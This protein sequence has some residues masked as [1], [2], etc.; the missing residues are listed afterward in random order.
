MRTMV[1]SRKNGNR[2]QIYLN[3]EVRKNGQDPILV[4]AQR[5]Q[6]FFDSTND[7]IAVFNPSGDVVDANPQLLK[8]FGYSYDAIVSKSMDVLFDVKSYEKLCLRFQ[9]LF[10][11]RARKSPIE[12]DLLT[13]SGRQRQVEISLSLLKGQYGYS[14][15][16][17]AIIRDVTRRKRI[18]DRSVQRAEELQKV[19]NAVPTILIV[20][21]RRK[22]I[23]K[24]NRSGLEAFHKE[25]R[26]VVG[27]RIGEALGCANH[28]SSLKGC[29]FGNRCRKCVIRQ[30]MLRCLKIGE[31]IL[32]VEEAIIRDSLK[33]SLF[34]YKIN[35]VPLEARGKRWGVV[36]LEDITAKKMAEL[37]SLKLHNSIARSNLELKKTLENFAQSQSRL[38]ESQKL[39]QIGLL[40]SGLAHNLKT[41]LSGI[42]GYSQL[43][44]MD[45]PDMKELDLI[46][47]ETE[48]MESIINNLMLKSRKEHENREEILNLNEILKI[49]LEFLSANMFYKHHVTTEIHLD[50]SLPLITGVYSHF[51]QSIMNIIQN[52]LDA[53]YLTD[54]KKLTIQTKHDD[55]YV[56][57]VV[58]DTG[59][60]IPKESIEKV[61]DIFYTTKP[62]TSNRREDE[63]YG[64][65][66]GLSSANYFIH[67]Y[68][69]HISLS[70][71]I[72]KGTTVTIQI[73]HGEKK[74]PQKI[75]RALIVDDSDT[76]VDML[77]RICQDIGIEAYGTTNGEKALELYTKLKPHVIV[78]DLCMP[79]LTG[80]EMMSEIRKL[81]ASQ[82]VVYISGYSE[83]PE[84][85]DWLA[86]EEKH[87]SLSAFLKKPFPMDSFIKVLQRMVSE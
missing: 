61:F 11:G 34:Y 36:S 54:E 62:T 5:Y 15:A 74:E 66:L 10:E 24:V 39:E 38:L 65:G 1:V 71:E 75:H 44:Q 7:A 8:L 49:E 78:T 27:R 55:K 69:G 68:G 19:F 32:N 85:R 18:E 3:P 12:C 51:S 33:D 41:P 14:K 81:N 87:P 63:P 6:A 56:C 60:G 16:I 80:P 82:H 30:S 79:G 35:V 48:V 28:R 59:C 21:N 84:F 50:A 42:K 64:T 72:G 25:E 57:V 86:Q 46:V 13:R 22:R 2:D 31:T 58:R 77:T 40:A 70:S 17:L 73:P 4:F 47:K 29:G 45:Y 76:M 26:E 20:V 37:E 52:A 67:Q 23:R 43:L 53:M 9:I 83:N